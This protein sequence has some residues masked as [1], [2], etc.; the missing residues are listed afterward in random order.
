M[1]QNKKGKIPHLAV[2]GGSFNPPHLG[3]VLAAEKFCNASKP[4]VLIVVPSLLSPHKEKSDVCAEKRL[5]MSRL[6]FSGV[7]KNV[8]ISDCEILRGGKSYTLYTILDIQKKYGECI[9]DLFVGSDMLMSFDTWFMFEKL[10]EKCHLYVMQRYDDKEIL[11]K[12]A[13]YYREKYGAVISF[14][15]GEYYC[16]SSTELRQAARRGDTELLTR[17]LPQKVLNYI[18]DKEL[19]KKGNN[20]V[21]SGENQRAN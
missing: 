19:Y 5:E 16:I 6:A 11:E 15:Q 10:F 21:F 7:Y 9:I 14:I 13:E 2:F 4:D 17:N 1:M 12:K 20:N 18:I 3:H 8:E